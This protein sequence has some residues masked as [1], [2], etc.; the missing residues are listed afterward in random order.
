MSFYLI[1]IRNLFLSSFFFVFW[2]KEGRELLV[3]SAIVVFLHFFCFVILVVS[4]YGRVRFYSIRLLL[5]RL[6]SWSSRGML[7]FF[8]SYTFVVLIG[9]II[10][11]LKYND[12]PGRI[13]QITVAPVELVG[14]CFLFPAT[15]LLFSIVLMA[16]CIVS[17]P[18]L[19]ICYFDGHQTVLYTFFLYIDGC[20]LFISFS[21][22]WTNTFWKTISMQIL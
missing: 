13:V 5:L 10:V 3:I 16:A 19:V 9:F 1:S 15:T 11:I 18:S 4:F 7:L 21:I 20:T 6:V 8:Y 14:N 17:F 12:S 2:E 22:R